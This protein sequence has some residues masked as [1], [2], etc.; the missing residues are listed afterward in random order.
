MNIIRKIKGILS[1]GKP[2]TLMDAKIK[3]MQ[4]IFNENPELKEKFSEI[5][6]SL[7][8][9]MTERE[10]DEMYNILREYEHREHERKRYLEYFE[11]DVR[12]QELYPKQYQLLQ[13]E[14]SEEEWEDIKST[15]HT[16]MKREQRKNK[17]VMCFEEDEV[18]RRKYEDIYVKLQEF[19]SDEELEK[20]EE[21]LYSYERNKGERK[22]WREYLDSLPRLKEKYAREYELLQED[23]SIDELNLLTWKINYGGLIVSRLSQQYDDYVR[24]VTEENYT[25]GKVETLYTGYV[26]FEELIRKYP[27]ETEALLEYYMPE[28]DEHFYDKSGNLKYKD[29]HELY[30]ESR[31]FNFKDILKFREFIEQ[32]NIFTRALITDKEYNIINRKLTSYIPYGAIRDIAGTYTGYSITYEKFLEVKAR[33]PRDVE[34]YASEAVGDEDII[35]FIRKVEPYLMKNEMHY[36]V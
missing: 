29:A 24:A 26:S 28:F 36:M 17:L 31:K 10:V 16:H 32:N 25:L 12:V 20:Y 5:Y 7:K 14:P 1:F 3:D 22:R 8:R 2:Q 18:L 27:K 21:L 19:L 33:Y 34:L 13:G 9:K 6:A 4:R 30:E 23:L 11:K 15:I 35:G